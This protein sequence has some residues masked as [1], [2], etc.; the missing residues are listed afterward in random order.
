MLF[1]GAGGIV[2]FF[3]QAIRDN[4]YIPPIVITNLT[5]LNRAVPIG[6]ADSALQNAIPYVERL[7]LPYRNNVFSLE[8]AALSYANSHKNRY[9]YRL[10]NFDADWNEVDSKHRAATYTNLDPGHYVFRVQ[11]SNSDG[12]WNERGVSLALDITPPWYRTTAFR[13]ACIVLGLALLWTAYRSRIR[14]LQHTFDVTLEARVGERTR[15]AR[16]LHDTL[17]QSFHGLLLRFET[18]SRLLPERPVE[19][20]QRLD[21]AIARAGEAVTEGRDA[22][23]GLR[24]S[25]VERND[26]A[27]AIRT[28]GDQLAT[29]ASGKPAPDFGVAVEGTVRE[30]HPILRDEIFKVIAEALRNA[31]R[32]AHATRVEID[33]RYDD[34][35]LRLR[36]RDDGRGMDQA[37]LVGRGAQGHYG[38]RGMQE[39]AAVIGATLTVWSEVGAGTEVELCL[40]ANRV[41]A[42]APRR[43]WWSTAR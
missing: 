25:T 8:F 43:R 32:H 21:E 24:A 13:L 22:V 40:P 26:L 29:D 23:Q 1:C 5:I 33:I 6:T 4:P 42:A 20:K 19:A 17:L 30:L 10:E 37:L 11:G 9:R 15:I 12:I 16:E 39:R 28:L 38:L 27:L 41:Y 34:D 7:T 14:Q 36:V 2:A 3:P 35:Q 31:F 18:V